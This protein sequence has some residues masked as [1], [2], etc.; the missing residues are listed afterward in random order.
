MARANCKHTLPKVSTKR[1]MC[2]TIY[3]LSVILRRRA[4][5]ARINPKTIIWYSTSILQQRQEH[6]ERPA[7]SSEHCIKAN[8]L[9]PWNLQQ[10]EGVIVQFTPDMISEEVR[11]RDTTPTSSW[12]DPSCY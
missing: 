1:N 10:I 7:G 12:F 3:R 9:T 11:V 2:A 5:F 4:N 6:D 8:R